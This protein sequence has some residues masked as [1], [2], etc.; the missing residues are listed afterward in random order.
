MS[1]M[2]RQDICRLK[3]AVSGQDDAAAM[4]ALLHA[5]AACKNVVDTMSMR[6]CINC[7]DF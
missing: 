5:A 7:H 6:M 4:R 3:R 2:K 1:G